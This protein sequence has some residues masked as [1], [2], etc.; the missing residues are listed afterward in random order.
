M[1]GLEAFAPVL[2]GVVWLS[3]LRSKLLPESAMLFPDCSTVP[4]KRDADNVPTLIFEAFVVSVVAE[5]AN[6]LTSAAA[7]CANCGT[8]EVLIPVMN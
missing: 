2:K 5:L 6:P 4:G 7:G 3:A 8:P 1:L